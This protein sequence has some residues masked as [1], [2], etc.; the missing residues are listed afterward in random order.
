MAE[1]LAHMNQEVKQQRELEKEL[2]LAIPFDQDTCEAIVEQHKCE[3]EKSIL[4]LLFVP[5]LTSVWRKAVHIA[6][7]RDTGM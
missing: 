2:C 3:E 6:Q 7:I 5:T 4:T 1:W